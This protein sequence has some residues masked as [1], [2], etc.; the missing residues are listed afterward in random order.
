[1]NPDPLMQVAK[2]IQG[3]MSGNI[4]SNTPPEINYDDTMDEK[5]NKDIQTSE[6][7][8]CAQ[9]CMTNAT[10]C[11]TLQLSKKCLDRGYPKTCTQSEIDELEKKCKEYSITQNGI[12]VI[13]CSQKSLDN[14]IKD[15]ATYKVAP[16]T[17]ERLNSAIVLQNTETRNKKANDLL[18]SAKN[19]S[20][21]IQRER[22]DVIDSQVASETNKTIDPIYWI[23]IAAV[24]T[25]LIISMISSMYIFF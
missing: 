15:C 18:I 16:C 19:D 2:N 25:M 22:Q 24:I 12:N 21:D 17:P 8:E 13:P 3:V 14:L 4:P 5:C 23:I 10:R 1:M 11:R 6:S 9:W 7:D 20:L